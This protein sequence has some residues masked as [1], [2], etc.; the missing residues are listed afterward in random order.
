M[1]Y[2]ILGSN[3][4][5]LRVTLEEGDK[6]YADS[7]SFISKTQN[8]TM[9]P[10]LAGGVISALERK[11]TGMTATLTEFAVKDGSGTG[12]VSVSGVFPGK[13]YQV[14]LAEGQ[15]FIIER[16]SLL[17]AESSVT[18]TIKTMNLGAMLFAKSGYY[19]LEL[20]GPGNA[21][22]HIVGD[23]IEHNITKDNLVEV[24][25]Q[26]VAGFDST[27]SYNVKS[28]ENIRTAMFG[29]IGLFLATFSGTGRLITHSVSRHKLSIEIYLEALGQQKPK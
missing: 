15:K 14:T 17:A 6:I 19:L 3:M 12:D 21:F 1:K 18:Y 8:V 10:K 23:I 27:L 20:V 29:G 7:G 22:I 16:Y 28:V 25:P 9:V 13:I 2:D 5:H 11:A 26:H 4:Q 24:D